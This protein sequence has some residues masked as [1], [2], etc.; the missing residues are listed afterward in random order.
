MGYHVNPHIVLSNVIHGQIWYDQP[1]RHQ[2]PKGV[3]QVHPGGLG[4]HSWGQMG[5]HLI[6]RSA[7]M[8]NFFSLELDT[9]NTGT[10]DKKVYNRCILGALGST[11]GGKWGTT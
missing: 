9:H 11:H 8:Q 7:Q 5:Y 3:H 1:D 2:G 6:C 10:R 4:E